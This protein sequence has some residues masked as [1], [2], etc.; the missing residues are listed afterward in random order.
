MICYFYCYL[1]CNGELVAV[2]VDVVDV[3]VVD[4]GKVII[5]VEEPVL[6]VVNVD[7]ITLFVSTT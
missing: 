1:Y 2:V 4:D 3:V 6:V 7:T 5:V